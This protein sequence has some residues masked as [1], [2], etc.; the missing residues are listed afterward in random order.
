M[1]CYCPDCT[2]NQRETYTAKYKMQCLDRYIAAKRICGMTGK[3]DRVKE[4]DGYGKRH[5]P[6]RLVKLK[7]EINRQWKIMKKARCQELEEA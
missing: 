5:G 2:D 6:D 3:T 4:I 7:A 1:P